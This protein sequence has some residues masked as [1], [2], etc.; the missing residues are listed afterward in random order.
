MIAAW[1]S[2][3]IG[4]YEVHGYIG[5]AILGLV[6]FRVMWG[7]WGSPHALFKDFV[8]KPAEIKAYLSKPQSQSPGHNPLGGL[9]VIAMLIIIGFQ[10]MSGLF[11]NDGLFF[12]GPL[13]PL[14]NDGLSSILTELHEINFTII[15]IIVALHIAAIV[16]YKVVHKKNLVIAMI[17]GRHQDNTGSGPAR[18]NL[19]ALFLA[20]LAAIIILVI[21]W[22]APAD[23]P[24]GG[25]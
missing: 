5:G 25:F 16:F 4:E 17:K 23:A 8:K 9:S 21:F 13:Y 24:F 6:I 14:I 1:I 15:Q 12:N 3:E 7:F 20:L 10:A 22:S 2:I 19:L 11:A 18:S